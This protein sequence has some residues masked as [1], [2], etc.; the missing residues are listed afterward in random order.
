[1]HFK[2]DFK[3]KELKNLPTGFSETISHP[4]KVEH[5][6]LIKYTVNSALQ[7]Y[8]TPRVTFKL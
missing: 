2:G 1:M 6:L 3:I 4:N 5:R 8:F 7:I